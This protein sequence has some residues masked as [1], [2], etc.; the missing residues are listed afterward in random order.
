MHIVTSI[1]LLQTMNTQ[2]F[3]QKGE[4]KYYYVCI[5]YSCHTPNSKVMDKTK[6]KPQD[7]KL[8]MGDNRFQ[9]H[10]D[11]VTKCNELRNLFNL[12]PI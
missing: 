11:V 5:P 6:E 2:T 3:T 10:E 7:I 9:N 4:D 1:W 12:L 8:F